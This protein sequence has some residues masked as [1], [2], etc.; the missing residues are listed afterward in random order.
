MTSQLEK[1]TNIV[2]ILPN[3]S[4]SKD[5]D[6]QLIE[7]SMRDIFFENPSTKWG[8]ENIPRPFPKKSKLDISLNQY[9]KVLHGLFLL[10]AK[11]RA[12]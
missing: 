7:Y 11:L 3:I 6:N 4:R 8:R 5:N 12:I 1:Q 2:H 10:Y 9:S